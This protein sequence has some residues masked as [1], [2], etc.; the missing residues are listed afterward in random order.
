MGAAAML[1]VILVNSIARYSHTLVP[2]PSALSPANTFSTWG[3][4]LSPLLPMEYI[5]LPAR[6]SLPRAIDSTSASAGSLVWLVLPWP[7]GYLALVARKTCLSPHLA[8]G[9]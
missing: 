2:V 9:G 5:P 3:G 8:G 4:A 6:P 7:G 1:P